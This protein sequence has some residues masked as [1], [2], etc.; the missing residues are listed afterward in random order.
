MTKMITLLEISL[1]MGDQAMTPTDPRDRQTERSMSMG[2]CQ[3][4][5]CFNHTTMLNTEGSRCGGWSTE[6]PTKR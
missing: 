4:V 3:I 2:D 1:H 5:Q 6:R